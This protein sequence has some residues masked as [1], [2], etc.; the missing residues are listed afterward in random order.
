MSRP[1]ITITLLSSILLV[2]QGHSA[3]NPE[4]VITYKTQKS[5]FVLNK[6]CVK[7]V[8]LRESEDHTLLFFDIENNVACSQKINAFFKNNM[9]DE[10]TAFFAENTELVKT[11]I[12]S[13][14]KTENGFS[15]AV[16][17]TEIANKILLSYTR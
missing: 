10:V 4:N 15:Q 11:K 7:G 17:N 12:V 6:N 16:P 9:G 13:E 14:L 8:S 3:E 2:S 5:E 1:V